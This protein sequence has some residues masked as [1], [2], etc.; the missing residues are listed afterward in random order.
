ILEQFKLIESQKN[1]QIGEDE[2][3][4][5]EVV[6]IT[7]YPNALLGSFEEEFLEIP[8]EVIITSMRENQRYFAVFNDKGLSNHFIVVSNAV[9]KDYSK[10]IHGNERVLRARLSDAMFFYQNDLQNGLK[11]EKLAKMTY[12]EGLGT[13]QDKSLR[14]IKIAEIL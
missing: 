9:C 12:L 2:E 1:I 3:L 7:E 8:S 13:M 11:P 10:I 4:L 14:E 5:A 6:A